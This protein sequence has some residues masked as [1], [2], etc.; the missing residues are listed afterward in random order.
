[1]I[2]FKEMGLRKSESYYVIK[3]TL[4]PL[5]K[6]FKKWHPDFP[7]K[8]LVFM[9]DGTMQRFKQR[10]TLSKVMFRNS[11]KLE[12]Q[13]NFSATSHSKGPPDG[14]GG[15]RMKSVEKTTTGWKWP[16]KEDKISHCSEDVVQSPH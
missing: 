16:S 11:Q 10:F 7:L 12:V 8:R 3:S 13:W 9:T 5:K 14:I 15:M 2:Y 1:M 6:N 4:V